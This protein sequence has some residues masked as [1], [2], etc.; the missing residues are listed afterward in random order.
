MKLIR[1]GAITLL[2]ALLLCTY[3]SALPGHAALPDPVA[4]EK[5]ILVRHGEKPAAG[6]GL[7]SCQG[8]NRALALP[9]TLLAR[10]GKPDFIFAPDPTVQ[11]IDDG[12]L[13]N[14]VRPFLTVAPLSV[15]L[16]LPVNTA[17][18]YADIEGL[19]AELAAPR[20]HQASVVVAWEHRQLEL[21]VKAMLQRVG[22]NASDVPHWKGSDFDSIY[23]LT[24]RRSAGQTT[25][26]FTLEHEALDGQSTTCGASRQSPSA[27]LA[28]SVPQAARLP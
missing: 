18:G 21:L 27:S 6:L 28:P 16:G 1:G 24:V 20:Y 22:G 19:Q 9:A 11:K 3:F 17:F 25:A 23:V 10:F 13:Y 15:Q 8:L 5:I 2:K 12:Q 7:L 26:R 14:Y 4:E